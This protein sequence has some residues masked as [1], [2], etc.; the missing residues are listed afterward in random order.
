MYANELG[1]ALMQKRVLDGEDLFVNK[2]DGPF[3][4]VADLWDHED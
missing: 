2:K 4:S 1:S 3:W